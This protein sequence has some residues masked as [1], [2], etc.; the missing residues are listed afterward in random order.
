MYECTSA[1][2]IT[3]A[4]LQLRS[5]RLIAWLASKRSNAH[6]SGITTLKLNEYASTAVARRQPEVVQPVMISVSMSRKLRWLMKI[7]PKKHD[8]LRLAMR[9][10]A[11]RGASGVDG[12]RRVRAFEHGLLGAAMALAHL[13]AAVEHIGPSR[14]LGI[15][16]G[17]IL[18]AREMQQR[19]DVRDGVPRLASAMRAVLLQAFEM[20]SGLS[21]QKLYCTSMMKSAGRV[22]KPPRLP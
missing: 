15:E 3:S 1:D 2:G 12:L 21:P 20:S 10:S 14:A 11:S 9:R 19:L 17:E 16:H 22:P 18:F 5:N 13:H 4:Y 8:G 6:S 7:V